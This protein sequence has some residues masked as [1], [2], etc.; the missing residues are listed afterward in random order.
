MMEQRELKRFSRALA[1]YGGNGINSSALLMGEAG[2]YSL[3]YIPFEYV[4]RNAR[5]VIVG[6]T[7]GTTQLQLAYA[8]AQRLL[9]EG[10]SYDV[11]LQEIKKDATFGGPSMRP[12]LL[13]MLRH[14]RFEQLLGVDNVDS[15]WGKS[16][17]LLHATS[18]VPNAA[19]KRGKMFAGSFEEVM[20]SPLLRECFED[21]LL[22]S[23]RELSKDALYIAL[24]PCPM[25]ALDYCVKAGVI[26][27]SQVLG[28]FCHPSGSGGSKTDYYLRLRA[29]ASL[30]HNDPTYRQAEWLDRAYARMWAATTRL[31]AGPVTGVLV[32]PLADHTTPV[33]MSVH[34]SIGKHVSASSSR[35]AKPDRQVGA[36]NF[37]AIREVMTTAGYGVMDNTDSNKYLGGFAA[38]KSGE[39]IYVAKSS[40]RL[41]SIKIKILVHPRFAPEQ[42]E[43]LDGVTTVSE[44]YRFHSNL[45]GFPKRVNTGRDEITYG[46]QIIVETLDGLRRFAHAFRALMSP[47]PVS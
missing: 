5:L 7:P 6:I 34:S 39:V 15:L 18:V 28:A 47:V 1:E 9:A 2:R 38:P 23:L 20:K 19:F 10:A 45:R 40:S 41:N 26:G 46:R 27:G 22:P 36:E 3:R 25:D 37:S 24:G 11:I 21:C 32:A 43:V 13:R 29:R 42:L 16:A 35:G 4:N 44:T 14:F 8:A 33:A 31:G 12:N 17:G 30:K